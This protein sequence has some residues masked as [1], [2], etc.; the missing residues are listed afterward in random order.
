VRWRIERG[1]WSRVGTRRR[2]PADRRA[3]PSGR[4]RERARVH[5]AVEVANFY[6]RSRTA[7]R[8]VYA[9]TQSRIH[10][11]VTYAFLRSLAQLDLASPRS[12]CSRKGI[13]EVPIPPQPA[14]Q[15]DANLAAATARLPIA[16]APG[17]RGARLAVAPA[18]QRAHLGAIV[19]RL[20]AA[21]VP[22]ANA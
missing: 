8:W 9:Q 10:V 1:C 7:Q 11:V 2:L 22:T 14:N 15:A 19:A 18:A 17:A 6:P 4:R 5:V 12:A 20:D 21:H 3:A 16:A 13:D